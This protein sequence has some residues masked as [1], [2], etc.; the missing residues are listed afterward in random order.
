MRSTPTMPEITLTREMYG[1]DGLLK[2]VTASLAPY[3]ATLQAAF[4]ELTELL[5][6]K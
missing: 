1:E 3:I 6:A 2:D 5:K 4:D